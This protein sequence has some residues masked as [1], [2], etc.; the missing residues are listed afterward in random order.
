MAHFGC[1]ECIL[2]QQTELYNI[3]VL[4]PNTIKIIV[5]RSVGHNSALQIIT[6]L[7]HKAPS[8]YR[9][10]LQTPQEIYERKTLLQG[11]VIIALMLIWNLCCH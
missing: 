9:P 1:L 8:S 10:I 6:H 2:Y 11:T 3:N 4:Q 5:G 7:V